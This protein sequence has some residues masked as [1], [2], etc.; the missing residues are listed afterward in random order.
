[1]RGLDR[2]HIEDLLKV[3]GLNNAKVSQIK[4]A[5]ELGKRVQ[6]KRLITPNNLGLPDFEE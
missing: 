1:M 4:A 6:G 3:P 2:A 5:I